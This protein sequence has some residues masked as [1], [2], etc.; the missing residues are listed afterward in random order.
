MP[1]ERPAPAPAD[2]AAIA[3]VAA[4]VLEAAQAGAGELVSFP[5]VALEI[6]ERTHDPKADAR[7]VAGFIARDPALAAGV[8]SVANSAAFRGVS[9]IESVHEAVARLGLGEVGRVA[10]AVASRKLLDPGDAA[11]GAEYGSAFFVRAVA[12]A[13]AAAGVALR[14]R[15]ARSDHVWLAAL[16]HDVGKPLAVRLLARLA[17]APGAHLTPIALTESVIDRV[18]VKVGEAAL[19]QWA[20][21][22]YLPEI[23]AHHHDATVPAEAVDLHL[24]RLTSALASL[25]DPA[26]AARAA[27]EIVQS[28]GAL[29]MS[30]PLV[31]SL[32][33]DLKAAEERARALVR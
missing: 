24:V 27:R 7:S 10:S 28:A 19:R 5:A 26:D 12:V 22:A 1:A 18:H 32:A 29:G 3:E 16:L 6:V 2:E 8:V 13:A 15:G 4:R 17:S 30:A 25:A 31:R 14:Q 11:G 21:P 9:E 20:L 23:C 33:T